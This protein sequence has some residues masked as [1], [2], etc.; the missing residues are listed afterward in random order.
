MNDRATDANKRLQYEINQL[1]MDLDETLE[2]LK[3]LVS[4]S[5]K[6]GKQRLEDKVLEIKCALWGNERDF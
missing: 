6:E 4:A 2:S 3:C 1:K 5:T